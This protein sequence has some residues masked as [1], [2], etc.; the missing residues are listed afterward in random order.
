VPKFVQ[1]KPITTD[2]PVVQ[3]DGGLKPG[4]RV[5]TLV[6]EDNDGNLSAPATAVVNVLGGRQPPRGPGIPHFPIPPAPLPR[7]PIDLPTPPVP[8]PIPDDPI[9]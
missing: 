5:F 1:G 4:V 2:E 7:P 3:V 6:V 9:D 8:Q